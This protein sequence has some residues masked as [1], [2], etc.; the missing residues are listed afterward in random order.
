MTLS[1]AALLI[2][3]EDVPASARAALRDAYTAAAGER[4]T[5]LEAAARALYREADLDCSDA[6][7]LVGLT[8]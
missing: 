6:R 3:D 7:E 5:H 1:V 8:A 4:R 2:H